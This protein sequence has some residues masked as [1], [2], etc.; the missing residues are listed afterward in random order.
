MT[1]RRRFS[2]AS[3]A[4]TGLDLAPLVW[5]S[6]AM[7]AIAIGSDGTVTDANPAFERMAGAGVRGRD[8]ATVV[9]A[10]QAEA[11]RSWLLAADDSWSARTWGI[12]PLGADA[13]PRDYGVAA[14]RMSSGNIVA[15]GDPHRN[16]DV[17]AAMFDVNASLVTE[18]R[19]LERHR[20]ALDRA[21]QTDALTGI[22]NR[23]AFDARLG[24]EVRRAQS[25]DR[26]ALVM[27]DIDDFKSLNDRFG[28]QAGDAVLRW[29]GAQLRQR[30]RKRDFMARYG[31]EEFV[32]ILAGTDLDGA[33]IWAEWLRTAIG[34]VAAPV[35]DITVTVSLGVAAWAP[36]EVGADVIGRAD[37]ALYRAKESGR[38]RVIADEVGEVAGGL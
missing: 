36:G 21:V 31:G 7:I 12:V 22:A 1:T 18:R 13:T 30:A 27:L 14:R 37:R 35:V 6:D 15:V 19:G 11:F 4:L 5:A 23:G 9:A 20:A 10:G 3:N 26:F 34:A 32:A 38:N 24:L 25:G 8:I 33:T 16:D 17:A 2:D 29:L 28:H